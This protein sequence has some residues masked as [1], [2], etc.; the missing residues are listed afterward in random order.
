MSEQ[1]K[2]SEARLQAA[3]E[4]LVSGKPLKVKAS[5]R[6]TLN[7]IN[8]EAGFAKGYVHKFPEFMERIKPLIEDYNYK[9]EQ[10]LASGLDIEIDA[11]LSEMDVLRA[12]LKK[13]E[14]LKEKY[15]TERDNAVEARKQLEM[16]YSELSFRYYELQ[17]TVKAQGSVMTPIKR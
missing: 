16:N 8:N 7:K 3:F 5:G 2:L 13:A 15:R 12:K 11:P 9:R 17:E 14:R 4:R 6:L 1:L 10:A